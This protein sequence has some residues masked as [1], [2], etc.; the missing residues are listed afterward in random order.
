MNECR[1]TS[2]FDDYITN[3]VIS[4]G[5]RLLFSPFNVF[6]LASIYNSYYYFL[7]FVDVFIDLPLWP[8][9]FCFVEYCAAINIFMTIIGLI[10]YWHS[11]IKNIPN[12]LAA[13]VAV[14]LLFDI[15]GKTYSG[16]YGL[17]NQIFIFTIVY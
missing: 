14:L 12:K 3:I 17:D 2:R 9:C 5:I 6:V 7:G 13:T 15:A 16:L 10:K 8:K 4:V 1:N 11:K